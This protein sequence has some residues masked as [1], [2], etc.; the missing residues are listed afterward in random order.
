MLYGR[1][2][3]SRS[4][5]IVLSLARARPCLKAEPMIFTYEMLWTMIGW[6]EAR[7]IHSLGLTENELLD[8]PLTVAEIIAASGSHQ[9]ALQRFVD[10]YKAWWSF[11]HAIEKAGKSGN[12][13]PLESDTLSRLCAERGDAKEALIAMTPV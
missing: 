3:T 11:H 10:A 13:S 4:A 12:L 9:A 8:V 1:K 5:A 7:T 2:R 6:A